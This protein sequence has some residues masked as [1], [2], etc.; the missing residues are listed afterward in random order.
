LA[1]ADIANS[2]SDKEARRVRKGGLLK[3]EEGKEKGEKRITRKSLP[4]GD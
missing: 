3:Q 2:A 1:Q 4:Q